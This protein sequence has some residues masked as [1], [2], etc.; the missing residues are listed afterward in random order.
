MV[1]CSHKPQK[2]I[3]HQAAQSALDPIH[4]DACK[5]LNKRGCAKRLAM[6]RAPCRV[7]SSP[8]GKPRPLTHTCTPPLSRRVTTLHVIQQ[9]LVSGKG[10]VQTCTTSAYTWGSCGGTKYMVIMFLAKFAPVLWRSMPFCHFTLLR[11]FPTHALRILQ[12]YGYPTKLVLGPLDGIGTSPYTGACIG[13]LGSGN[14]FCWF[15]RTGCQRH[16]CRH[17]R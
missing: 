7:P 15:G 11:F 10:G 17:A 4:W 5:K 9:G 1:G 6:Q 2:N 14:T 12:V 3:M 8:V 13:E 16:S